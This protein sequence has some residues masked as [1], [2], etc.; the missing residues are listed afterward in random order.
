[1][2]NKFSVYVPDMSCG[3]CVKRITGILESMGVDGFVVKLD[4]KRIFSDSRLK[5]DVLKA[6]ADAGYPVSWD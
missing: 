6:L 2:K 1:M 5:E 3:H 4:E